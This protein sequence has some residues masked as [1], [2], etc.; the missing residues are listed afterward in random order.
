MPR[1]GTTKPYIRRGSLLAIP[2]ILAGLLWIDALQNF[3]YITGMALV[4]SFVLFLVFPQVCTM[5][6]RKPLYYEDLVA[7]SHVD[8]KMRFKFQ[9]Y[10]AVIQS[11]LLSMFVASLVDYVIYRLQSTNLSRQEILY[12]F[13]GQLS[14]LNEAQNW[15]G[16]MLMK[17]LNWR[18]KQHEAS[19]ADGTQGSE[20]PVGDDAENL[21]LGKIEMKGGGDCSILDLLP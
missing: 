13:G 12:L 7:D 4:S 17:I 20:D 9:K 11:V 3:W 14:I 10:F 16:R 6:H 21:E 2:I 15:S 19:L 5:T 18:K 8:T 1:K